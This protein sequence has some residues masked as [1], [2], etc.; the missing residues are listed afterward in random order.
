MQALVLSTV[1]PIAASLRGL[2]V[3]RRLNVSSIL[4][5]LGIAVSLVATIL[6]GSP[7]LLLLRESILTLA[8]GLACFATLPFPRPLMF[9]FGRQMVAGDDPIQIAVFN[10]RAAEPAVRSTHRRITAVWGA[11]LTLE[12]CCKAALVL[13]LSTAQVLVLSPFLFNGTVLLTMLWTVRYA[14]TRRAAVAIKEDRM[15]LA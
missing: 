13:A 1:Y 5:L 9:F 6:G 10:R 11:A 15:Q 8:L 3:K 14:K 2:A 4:V 7:R 12:F